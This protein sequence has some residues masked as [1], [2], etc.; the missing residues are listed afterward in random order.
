MAAKY[1]ILTFAST[2]NHEIFMQRAME[3]AQLGIGNVSPN[4]MVGCV[5]VH[6]GKII[7]EGWHE[8]YGKSHAEINAINSVNDKKMLAE[9]I[10]YVTLEPCSHYGKTPPCANAIIDYGIKKVV[11]STID[12]NP[13]VSGKGIAMLKQAGVDVQTDVLVDACA[14]M[15]R[16]FL[17]AMKHQKPYVILKWAESRDGFLAPDKNTCSELDFAKLK[18]LTGNIA[19]QLNHKWRTEED[20]ILIGT[21]TA[22]M[23]NPQLTARKWHGRNPIRLVL[24]LNNRLDNSLRVFNAEAKTYKIMYEDVSTSSE[25]SSIPIQR[26]KPL[27]EQILVQCTK[28]K[29][30]SLIVEGGAQLLQAFIQDNQWQEARVFTANKK[31]HNGLKAPLISGNTCF[32]QQLQNDVLRFILPQ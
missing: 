13:L 32:S 12:P 22:R 3:L 8:Q 21:E 19:Q 7:G 6:Q 29:I 31:L 11:I 1:K 30:Q 14:W 23:D 26:N 2:M 4:P 17:H 24:D 27:V 18:Q 9:S 10:L 28:L 15:N 16:R 5:I 20:A 25:I